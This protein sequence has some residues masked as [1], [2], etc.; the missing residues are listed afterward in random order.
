ML[1]TENGEYIRLSSGAVSS[2]VKL[3][4]TNPVIAAY[5]DAGDIVEVSV[6]EPKPIKGQKGKID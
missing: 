3:D 1:L 4:V 5:M 2:D 6:K